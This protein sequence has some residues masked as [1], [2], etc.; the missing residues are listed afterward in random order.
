MSTDTD[1]VEVRKM[2]GNELSFPVDG[3]GNDAWM[4]AL[5]A[6]VNHLI[7]HDFHKLVALLYRIDVN[8]KKLKQLLQERSGSDTGEMI[9]QLI[10]ERQL[11]KIKT[12]RDPQPP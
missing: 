3:T 7:T 5:A 11:Q 8:E 12:R 6:A 9:A 4:A 1:M 10:V 2:I